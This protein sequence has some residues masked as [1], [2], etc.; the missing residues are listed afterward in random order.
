MRATRAG[1]SRDPVESL[2]VVFRR[3]L[4]GERVSVFYAPCGS[5][6]FR[7]DWKLSR[8]P[9]LMAFVE[10]RR[11]RA[12]QCAKAWMKGK[13]TLPSAKTIAWIFA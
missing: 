12:L 9:P 5:M 4:L 1:E 7:T 13:V 10:H 2:K 6:T 11:S 8:N 3:Q